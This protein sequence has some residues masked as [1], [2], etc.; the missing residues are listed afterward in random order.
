[1]CLDKAK[2]ERKVI[3]VAAYNEAPFI[4]PCM[5]AVIET[6]KKIDAEII[7]SINLST[8]T[9][10]D[11]VKEFFISNAYQKLT[12][13]Y[14]EIYLEATEHHVRLMKHV[15]SGG[16]KGH[17][18]WCGADDI[19]EPDF[20]VTALRLLTIN[21]QETTDL[22]TVFGDNRQID[23]NGE[24]IQIISM[25]RNWYGIQGWRA[26]Q[27]IS[28][29]KYPN[30]NGTWVPIIVY[31]KY[32]NLIERHWAERVVIHRAND[33]YVWMLAASQTTFLYITE[34]FAVN[35]RIHFDKPWIRS[36][37]EAE[38]SNLRFIE[39]IIRECPKIDE[40]DHMNVIK[41]TA[42]KHLL[43]ILCN[44]F[45][46]NYCLP[47]DV[48]S[49]AER[50]GS[51]LLFKIVALTFKKFPSIAPK[52]SLKIASSLRSVKKNIKSLIKN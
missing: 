45:R 26:M 43:S 34:G 39:W 30:L 29:A 16:V 8:D 36:M 14:Q 38:L 23:K 37:K 22:I 13:L 6:A 11:L 48:Y 4:I 1:M 7:I 32:I 3:V 20:H 24:V 5:K 19:L 49:T 9:T 27:K 35:Y 12:V 25:R 2:V 51:P 17:M 41:M 47:E 21:K 31:E 33:R 15:I 18:I 40:Y 10:P 50:V 28:K 42:K 44:S 52:I 46:P